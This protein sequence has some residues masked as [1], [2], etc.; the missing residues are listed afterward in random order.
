M[1]TITTDMRLEEQR[2]STMIEM[3][4]MLLGS[5]ALRDLLP[6]DFSAKLSKKY[7]RSAKDAIKKLD[8][9]YGHESREL[10]KHLSNENKV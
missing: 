10:I 3:F 8:D 7:Q 1:S 2:I 6:R 4:I 9:E 5:W